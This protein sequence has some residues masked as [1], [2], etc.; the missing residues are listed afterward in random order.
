M[1]KNDI[2]LTHDS[3]IR[4][5]VEYYSHRGSRREKA[6][7]FY[8]LGRIYENARD[9]DAAVGAY[10]RASELLEKEDHRLRGLIFNGIGN[11]YSEQLSYAEALNMYSQASEAFR[12]EG[13]EQ[14]SWLYIK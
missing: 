1:E 7:T 11:L 9:F 4:I 14:K 2:Y 8:Y 10:T 13:S 5:A 3:V 6:K 12:A